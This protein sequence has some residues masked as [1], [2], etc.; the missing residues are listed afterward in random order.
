M[1]SRETPINDFGLII[2][3]ILPGLLAL[4][5][6]GYVISPIHQLMDPSLAQPTIAGFLLVTLAS[7]GMGLMTST[8]RWLVIDT[9]HHHT[10]VVADA[11]DFAKLQANAAAFDML[12]NYQY[13]YYQFYGNTL[14]ALVWWELVRHFQ[15]GFGPKLWTFVDVL[16]IIACLLLFLGSRDTLNKYYQRKG[17]VLE[18]KKPQSRTTTQTM[19]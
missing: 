18:W 5:G 17:R 13:R 19:E 16:A 3:Y 4:H 11:W 1:H 12:V 2:A 6:L 8:V 9:I 14:I 10:G 15:I 7:V